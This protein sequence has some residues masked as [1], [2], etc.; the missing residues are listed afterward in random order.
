M[1]EEHGIPMDQGSFSMDV[2][3]N[4]EDSFDRSRL[5]L[6]SM[7]D[8]IP[9]VGQKFV[10]HDAAYDFYSEFAKRTGFSIRRHRTEGKDGVGSGLTRRYFVCHR[11]GN[12][13]IKVTTD[14]LKQRRNRK[15]SRCGCSAY[16]R[17][18]KTMDM[19]IPEWRITGFKN[20]HNHELLEPNE[21]RFLPAYRKISENDKSRILMFAKT[22]ISVQQMMRLLELEKCVEPGYLSFTEKDVR[23]LL[24]TCKKVDQIDIHDLLRICRNIKERDTNFRYEFMMDVNNKLENIAWSYAPSIQS[25]EIFGDVVLFDTSRRLPTFDMPLG[26]WIGINNYGMPC[27]FGCVLLREESML[28]FSW[29]IKVIF[30]DQYLSFIDIFFRILKHCVLDRHF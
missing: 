4:A 1:L 8:Q 17:V 24:Q 18:S 13:P 25:Y 14:D 12:T 19:G 9:Y 6:E 28:S 27:L 26:I 3:N 22:G 7:K 15:S 20:Y 16:L 30:F 5:S 21:V 2:V 29:A 10:T 23:N 11:A